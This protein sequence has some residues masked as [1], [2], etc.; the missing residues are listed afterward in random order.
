M[1]QGSEQL[2][3]KLFTV[4]AGA[5]GSL[6]VLV[7]TVVISA[8]I[9]FRTGL[10]EIQGAMPHLIADCRDDGALRQRVAERLDADRQAS[11]E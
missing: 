3:V 2:T 1:G 10:S 11:G 5:L 4:V 7:L 8:M 9:Q 6:M